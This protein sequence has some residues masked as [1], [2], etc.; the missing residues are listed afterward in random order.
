M[1]KMIVSADGEVCITNDGATILQKM[2]IENQI[3]KIMVQLSNSQV[4]LALLRKNTMPP[5]TRLSF[6]SC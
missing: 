6:L 5:V 3:A 4:R 1:D 2:E